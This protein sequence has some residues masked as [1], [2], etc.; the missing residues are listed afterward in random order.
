MNF[1]DGN[2]FI[3]HY[4]KTGEKCA[5][6]KIGVVELKLLF[7]YY[8][9]NFKIFSDLEF[10]GTNIAGI[11]PFS[12]EEYNKFGAEYLKALYTLD[13]IPL[14]NKILPGFEQSIIQQIKSHII[15]LQDIEPYLRTPPWSHSLKDKKVLVISPFANSIEKQYKIKD[16]IWPNGILPDFELK[17]IK[18][19][20]SKVINPSTPFNSTLEAAQWA[21]NE[22]NK[23]DYDVAIIGTGGASILLTAHAKKMGKIG[24]HMGGP[25]QILFGIRGRRWDDI[26]QFKTLYNDFWT[27]PSKDEIPEKPENVEG[28]CYY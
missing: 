28:G 13:A 15:Q 3:S 12:E 25:T 26:E 10:E 27:R 14:W 18:Y 11:Y 9:K 20:H 1:V 2:N 17:T 4:L 23:I 8:K 21:E 7:S 22:M 16:K 6:G 24:I 5:V 19:P